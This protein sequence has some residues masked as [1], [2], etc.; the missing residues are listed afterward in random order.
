MPQTSDIGQQ[1]LSTW[2]WSEGLH[3]H[4]LFICILCEEAVANRR[5]A[6]QKHGQQLNARS[7]AKVSTLE[8]TSGTHRREWQPMAAKTAACVKRYE[9]DVC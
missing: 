5:V 6:W 8:P 1:L 4:G 2:K 7:T 9:L 3:S